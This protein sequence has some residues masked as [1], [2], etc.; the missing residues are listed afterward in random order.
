[1]YQHGKSAKRH[2]YK[3][4][5][6]LGIKWYSSHLVLRGSEHTWNGENLCKYNEVGSLHQSWW[7]AW[8]NQVGS[9]L[10]QLSRSVV[11]WSIQPLTFFIISTHFHLKSPQSRSNQSRVL[12]FIR[13][14]GRATNPLFDIIECIKL[15]VNFH[16]LPNS[17]LFN[18]CAKC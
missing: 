8:E 7:G 12:N 9:I 13:S 16:H 3:K 17:A 5:V 1:M 10:F 11:P 18:L 6:Y 14:L 4:L 2:L 15:S